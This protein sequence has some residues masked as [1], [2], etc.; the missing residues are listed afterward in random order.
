METLVSTGIATR[1]MFE[2][3]LPSPERRKKGPYVV[4]EC[5]EQIPCDP[6]S[7]SCP[8]KIVDMGGNINNTPKCDVDRCTGC[9]SCVGRCPGLACFVIDETVGDGKIKITFPYEMVPVPAK[10]DKVKALGRDGAVVGDAEIVRVLS[11]PKLDHTNIITM[12]VDESLI[13]D[14]RN[15]SCE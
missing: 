11:T 12:L 9:G 6:C 4:M 13:Y 10:G 2:K 14:A 8:L 7:T 1:E 5:Y 15:I 3:L